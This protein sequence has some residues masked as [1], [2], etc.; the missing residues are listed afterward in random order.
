MASPY[1]TAGVSGKNIASPYKKGSKEAKEMEE[2]N[3]FLRGRLAENTAKL[4]HDL[5]DSSRFDTLFS[6]KSP[7]DIVK[8]G[9]RS[10]S[11]SPSKDSQSPSKGESEWARGAGDRERRLALGPRARPSARDVRMR[12]DEVAQL[13][14]ALADQ[15]KKHADEIAGYQRELEAFKEQLLGVRLG[16]GEQKKR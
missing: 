11:A 9:G 16:L 14:K 15:S 4:L 10:R 12:E 5:Q 13:E 7:V 2:Y 6:D 8:T 3:S 1:L